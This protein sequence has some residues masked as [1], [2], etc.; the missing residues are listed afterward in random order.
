MRTVLVTGA[1]GFIGAAVLPQLVSE[2][3]EVHAV[4]REHGLPE[5]EGVLAHAADLLSP[6]D[7]DALVEDVRPSHLLHLAWYTTHGRYWS[8]DQNV[9]WV[10]ASLRLLRAFSAAGG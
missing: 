6:R 7:I 9:A 10:E 4:H 5:A 3:Y 2:G 8:S 1:S